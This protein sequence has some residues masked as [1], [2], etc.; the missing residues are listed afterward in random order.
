MT[1][2]EIETIVHIYYSGA[3]SPDFVETHARQIQKL[4]KCDL[5][6]EIPTDTGSTYQCTESGIVFVR[7]GLCEVPLPERV[8]VIPKKD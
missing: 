2:G 8:W 6:K 4:V 3:L 1:P 5:L 7:D